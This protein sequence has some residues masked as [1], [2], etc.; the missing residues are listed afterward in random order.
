MLRLSLVSFLLLAGCTDAEDTAKPDTGGGEDTGADIDSGE[1]AE[2]GESGETGLTDEDGDGYAVEGGDCNDADPSVNPGA[3]EVWYDGID[4]DCDGNDADQDGDGYEMSGF[5]GTDCDD[6]DPTISP[7]ASEVCDG[8][9][10]DCD[11]TVDEDPEPFWFLDADGDGY[12]DANNPLTGC[13]GASGYV[14][15]AEDCDDEAADVNAAAEEVCDGKDNNCDGAV[16]EDLPTEP[17]YYDGDGDGYGDSSVFLASCYQPARYVESWRDCD[18]ADA[19]V[20]PDAEERCDGKDND[21]DGDV[22]PDT[23]VDALVYYTDADGDGHG[24]AATGWASCVAPADPVELGDDCDDADASIYPDAVE[25]CNSVDDDCDG[26]VDEAGADGELVWYADDD[27]DGFGNAGS[28]SLGCVAPVGSVADDT[29]CDDT[30]GSVSPA[31]AETCNGGD[32]DCD[33][34]V[35]EAGA[36]GETTWFADGDGDGYGVDAS[37]MTQCDAPLGSVADG[38]DCDDADSTIFPGATERCDAVDQDC[39][40]T[41]DDDAGTALWIDTSGVATDVSALLGAGTVAAPIT[42][43]DAASAGLVVS[44]G[45]LTLCDGTWYA[46]LSFTSATSDVSVRSRNGAGTTTVTTASDLGGPTAS[47][48][49]VVDGTVTLEGLTLTG[50]NGTAGVAGGG[51]VV[52]RNTSYGGLPSEPTVSLIDSI[53]TGNDTR[54]GGGAAIYGYGWLELVD[55]L[56]EDNSASIAGG[57]VWL[58]NVGLLSC[59]ATA[60]GSAGLLANSSPIGGAGY[61]AS[62]FYGDVSS[63]GCDWGD[64]ASGDDN[65][66]ADIQQNPSTTDTYCYPNA[67]TLSDTITCGYGACTA[68]TDASCP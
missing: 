21:C 43:G 59:T 48:V 34:A 31:G 12:G 28:S 37:G 8:K 4:Q 19:S 1:T 7:G 22:D 36:G 67:S 60:L 42:V 40:G 23:S 6:A 64:D 13:T 5:G 57:G 56:I 49:Y 24:D 68:S 54:Y 39:D 61:L 50:G 10:Q 30:D 45:E 44:S 52:S 27:S 11:G 33:G 26:A 53:V 62:K 55:S 29:D 51:L 63:V 17:W 16:D 25:S 66:S 9:D 41:A 3:Q 38:G 18:D 65:S 2:T 58:Q 14:D 47:V 46:R 32:D 35:D 20:F 15:N